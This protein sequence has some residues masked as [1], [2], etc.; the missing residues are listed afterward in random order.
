ML[1]LEEQGRIGDLCRGCFAAIVG[2]L[3]GAYASDLTINSPQSW[4]T[5]V[6]QQQAR[7]TCLS[8]ARAARLEMTQLWQ[9]SSDLS[10]R[11]NI[12]SLINQLDDFIAVFQD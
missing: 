11:E 4:Q 8:I 6:Q 10:I 1:D 7:L 2:H 5:Y 3:G 9:A 12:E